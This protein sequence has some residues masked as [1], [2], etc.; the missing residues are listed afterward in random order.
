MAFLARSQEHTPP[1]GGRFLRQHPGSDR[2][3][4]LIKRKPS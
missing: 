2:G 4:L 3:Q 1:R